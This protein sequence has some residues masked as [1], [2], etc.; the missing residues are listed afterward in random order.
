M[1]GPPSSRS[2]SQDGGPAY[3][4]SQHSRPKGN[5]PRARVG[6]LG[7]RLLSERAARLLRGR[8]AWWR[9][10]RRTVTLTPRGGRRGPSLA[11]GGTGWCCLPPQ[12]GAARCAD[13]HPAAPLQPCQAACLP[14]SPDSAGPTR[15]EVPAWG[16]GPSPPMGAAG[17]SPPR[18]AGLLGQRAGVVVAAVGR[19]T[20]GAPGPPAAT[21]RPPEVCNEMPL[22]AA[23]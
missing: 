4:R 13:G 14:A 8:T 16:A 18:S 1:S 3:G 2:Q 20:P 11:V 10:G 12:A 15:Q 5:R 6:G 17:S 19:L 22:R 9:C 21:K 23:S 7:L